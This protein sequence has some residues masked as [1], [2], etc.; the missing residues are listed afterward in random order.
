MRVLVV[1]DDPTIASA[2]KQGL[3]QESFAVD[4]AYDGEDGL[5]SACAIAYDLLILDIML[6]GINGLEI[7]RRLREVPTPT[8]ILILSAKGQA[9]DKIAGLNLGA[10]D[11]LA[12]PFSFGEL[13]ARVNSL[14][15]RPANNLGD[16]L[17]AGALSLNAATH[18]VQRDGRCIELSSKE[19]AVLEYLL[20]NKNRTVSKDAIITH[21]WDFDADIL[22]HTVEVFVMR[23]RAKIDKP[24][25]GQAL[26]KTIHGLGYK[27]ED[28]P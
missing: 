17:Y 21:A 9:E 7:T 23:L 16:V 18:F 4:V 20:R 19:F 12:K 10:D 25:D 2:I 27:I 15:R 1:E 11:Y 13:L 8:R 5:A 6:P 28:K 26:L 14:L 3:A 24:F 22:P